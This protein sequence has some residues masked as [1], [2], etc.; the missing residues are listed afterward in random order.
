MQGLAYRPPDR[1][2]LTE[3]L[4]DHVLALPSTH[5]AEVVAREGEPDRPVKD[6]ILGR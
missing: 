4:L 3:D 6:V 5:A 2:E 1:D